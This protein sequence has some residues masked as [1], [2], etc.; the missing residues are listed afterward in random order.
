MTVKA[1]PRALDWFAVATAG[2]HATKIRVLEVMAE[3]GNEPISPG[4]VAELIGENLGVVSYH[5]RLLA[6]K[7]H[8]RLV[9]TKP[10]R[11]AL[12]HFY[13]AS[14]ELLLSPRQAARRALSR[15]TSRLA[16]ADVELT[17]ATLGQAIHEASIVAGFPPDLDPDVVPEYRKR[18]T[19]IGAEL[20]R[21]VA[22]A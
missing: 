5:I 13:V 15:S 19:R 22:G 6:E 20:L 17:P 7:G 3:R 21:G 2:M 18:L 11:G 12:A 8:V 1:K 4:E 14:D 9:S 10:R 16:G